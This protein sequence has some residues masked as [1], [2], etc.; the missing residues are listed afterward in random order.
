MNAS[1]ARTRSGGTSIAFGRDKQRRN[2]VQMRASKENR[3]PGNLDGAPEF[4]KQTPG[5]KKQI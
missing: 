3:P 5:Q 1:P 4:F 2:L